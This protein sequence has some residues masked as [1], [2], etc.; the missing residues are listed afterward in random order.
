MSANRLT[1]AFVRGGLAACLTLAIAC[2]SP[3]AATGP[4]GIT[5]AASRPL[6]SLSLGTGTL[7]SDTV[8]VADSTPV[9]APF[10]ATSWTTSNGDIAFVRNGYVVGQTTGMVT[11]KATN[12]TAVDSIRLVV[13]TPKYPAPSAETVNAV[14]AYVGPTLS[15]SAI[16]AKGGVYAKYEQDFAKFAET[17]WAADGAGNSAANYY[18][19]ALIYY[20]WWARTGNPTYLDRAHQLAL[21]HRRYLIDHAYNPQP[22]ELMIDGVAL[23]ALVTGDQRSY[24]TVA[25]TADRLGAA[26][27]YWSRYIGTA[28]SLHNF[29]ARTRARVLSAVLN[30]WLLKVPSPAG[31]DYAARLRDIATKIMSI[32]G[33]DGS[34]R[35]PGQCNYN[36]PFM[37]GT[38]N[39]VFIRYY[40]KFEADPRI[41]TSVKKA[42][43][44]MW[45]KDWVATSSAFKYLDGD[46]DGT[47]ASPSPDLNNL[48]T[49][50][51]AFIGKVQ[52]SSTYR[53]RADAI[54][55]GG[56]NRAWLSGSKQFNQ[57]YT[58][59]FRYFGLRF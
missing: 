52:N 23:H 45:T 30:A 24:E 44:Y 3:D 7:G 40:Q 22:Y 49:T 48:I 46:C 16:S 33:T 43:D 13:K 12:G 8:L 34:Y 9:V 20:V 18:D 50:G 53:S 59:S 58:A 38:L 26:T 27:S 31:L 6:T 29:D 54:F 1:L 56:V 47:K 21:N 15:A 10:A 17:H 42:V 41:V 4:T 25:R 19:R 36:K 11:I 55:A 5:P 2:A 14:L 32:Q 39:E 35:T 37:T 57:E 51:Y 28:D